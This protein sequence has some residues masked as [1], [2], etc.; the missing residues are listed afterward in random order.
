MSYKIKIIEIQFDLLPRK[1]LSEI[2]NMF[3]S[4]HP[5]YEI[6]YYNFYFMDFRDNM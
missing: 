1:L 2:C 4:I 5:F 6:Y 3:L